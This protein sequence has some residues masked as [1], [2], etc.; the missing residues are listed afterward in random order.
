MRMNRYQKNLIWVFCTFLLVQVSLFAQVNCSQID[1]NKVPGKWTWQQAGFG[2]Q[3]I[4]GESIRTELK[5]VFPKANA[6]LDVKFSIAFGGQNTFHHSASPA[7]YEYYLLLKKYE[8]LRGSGKV[9]PEG[10]TGAWVYMVANSLDGQ[11][12]PLPGVVGFDFYKYPSRILVTHI[13]IETDAAGNRIIYTKFRPGSYEMQGYYFSPKK[14][15]PLRKL[16][17]R[18][19]Y[20]SYKL[21]HE[22]RLKEQIE[23]FEKLVRD[24]QKKYDGLTATEKKE[25]NYWPDI[26]RKNQ[27]FLDGYKKDMNAVNAWF[28]KS[29]TRRDLD[30]DAC[31]ESVNPFFFLPEKL[32]AP[33]ETGYPVWVDDPGFFDKTK[34]RDQ[35]QCLTLYIRRQ[36]SDLPKKEFMDC[37]YKNFNLNVLYR[38]TG[39]VPPKTVAANTL[40]ASFGESKPLTRS[41]PRSRILP[42]TDFRQSVSGTFHPGWEGP[43]GVS[44][45]EFEKESWLALTQDGEWNPRQ[46]NQEIRDSFTLSFQVRWNADI[47]YNSGLLQICF[48]D[49]AYD[50]AQE[51]Y[52]PFTNNPSDW[53]NYPGY[54]QSYSR[55][56]IWFD[57]WWNGGGTITVYSYNKAGFLQFDKRI[58]L[59][60]FF[61]EKNDH[62]LHISRKGN[63]L[64]VTDN[65]KLIA[66]LPAVFLPSARYNFFT[67]GRYKG[68][69]S[70]NK[71]EVF[72][73]RGM[74]VNY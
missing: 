59:P 30:I 36:D 67:L 26:I 50:Q 13:K 35:A 19:V 11:S 1:L 72:L 56:F 49:L 12:F 10:E 29:L 39:A 51:K 68:E 40:S 23:K 33:A 14:E 66:D 52:M 57:P 46:Y 15:I 9:Q 62:R 32:E 5:R 44:I 18:E 69:F 20:M 25:Q 58:T 38:H 3:W 41:Q 43:A 65:G 48:S 45:R 73:L 16:S 31:V 22:K 37:F 17:R 7:Y 24:D 60:D 55:V 47:S 6:G 34:P 53:G 27:E 28:T 74:E 64:V 70:D 21:H 2:K 4:L 61:R 71:A 54:G 63:G 8:C 42:I